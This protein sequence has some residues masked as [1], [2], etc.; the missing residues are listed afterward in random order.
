M[1]SLQHVVKSRHV[2]H[3]LL[4][5]PRILNDV[6]RNKKLFSYSVVKLGKIGCIGFSAIRFFA[7]LD[8]ARA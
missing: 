4:S 3:N 5:Y 6:K 1:T 2:E 7:K 8:L